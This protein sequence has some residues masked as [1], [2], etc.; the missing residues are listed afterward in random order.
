MAVLGMV[1]A[2]TMVLLQEDEHVGSRLEEG[3]RHIERQ[4][5]TH[6]RPEGEDGY[7]TWH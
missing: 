3:A 4:L 5:W 1:E 6:N 7:V 2:R